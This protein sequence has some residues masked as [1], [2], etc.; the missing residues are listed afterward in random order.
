MSRP[1]TIEIAPL[2]RLVEAR[3]AL[4]GSK[5]LTNRALVCAALAD[6]TSSITGALDAD[7]TAA[8][9]RGVS[10]LGASI[11]RDMDRLLVTGTGGPPTGGPGEIDVGQ[12][13][14]VAR[15]LPPAAAL[16][17]KAYR[18]DGDPQM[19]R[20]SMGPL[21][22]ALRS[23]G[24]TIDPAG[25]TALPFTISGGAAGGGVLDLPGHV[26]SQFSSGLMMAAPLME[27]G[28]RIA[29]TTPL[30]SRPYVDMTAA[31]M[32]DFGVA[33][34]VGDREVVVPP[35]SY[36]ATDH[37]V[38]PDASAASYFFALAA[39]TGGRVT[40]TGLGSDSRQGELELVRVLAAMGADVSLSPDRVAVKGTGVLEGIT[41]DLSDMSDMVPTLAVVAAFA[42]G[43][44]SI[45]G[46]GFIRGK[47]SDRIG[48]LAAQLRACGV[49][50]EE[51]PDGLEVRPAPLRHGV[52]DSHDDHRLAMAFTVLGLAGPGVTISDPACVTKSFPSFFEVVESL[53]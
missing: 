19:R 45:S 13:G 2:E 16:G 48:A 21:L 49:E 10:V 37:V 33:A 31:V 47:E 5:S 7:D 50:V 22:D 20:R 1:E 38:E 8:M 28:L 44:T 29:L 27:T 18:F 46:V 15:F 35:G 34:E 12:A 4:P 52:I 43:P 17:G 40:V 39:V 25:A 24:A 36:R 41:V 30:V 32:A 26:S 9:I 51:R 3:V 6:G 42:D 23:L 11:G 53:R 14:T